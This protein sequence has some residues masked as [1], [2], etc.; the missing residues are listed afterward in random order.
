MAGAGDEDPHPFLLPVMQISEASLIGM[1][2]CLRLAVLLM[3]F[4]AGAAF[5]QGLPSQAF[6][7]AFS[8]GVNALN[9]GRYEEALKS[10]LEADALAPPSDPRQAELQYDLGLALFRLDRFRE[11]AP[12]FLRAAARSPEREAN[13]RYFAG[14]AFYRQGLLEEARDELEKV[15]TAA[16]ASSVAAPARDLIG[17]IDAARPE[18]KRLT[19][20]AGLGWQYDSNVVLLPDDA[21][22]PSGI[23]D[24]KDVRTVGTFQAGLQLIRSTRWDGSLDY[25]FYQSRY[26]DLD[27]FNVQSHDLGVIMSHRPSLRPYRFEF[28]YGFSD[29][30]VDQR[31]YL[32]THTLGWKMDAA[33]DPARRT[34]LEYRY[35]NKDFLK[36]DLFPGQ[37]E[38]TGINHAV[39]LSH[40]HFFAGQQGDLAIGYTYDRDITR[41]NDWDY[42]GHRFR[43]GLIAP[44]D[45][46]GGWAQAALEAEAVF[47]PYGNPNSLSNARPAEKRNDRIQTYTLTLSRPF[48]PWLSGTAQVLYN[49]NASNL[50]AF[51]YRRRVASVFVTAAY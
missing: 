50:D 41:G 40:D 34:R 48:T 29:A 24:K 33:A 14:V 43:L 26:Q 22:I 38:R 47:R 32:R 21:P 44:P 2:L 4:G 45:W 13:A 6:D 18:G 49:I 30:R 35:Q 51:D 25:R 20:K 39:G 9:Q 8:K 28:L 10:L 27:P 19:L 16:N 12:R 5:A 3:L 15:G 23:S 1:R 17:Q 46:I 11:A 31:D 36:S 37:G 7:L 42:R